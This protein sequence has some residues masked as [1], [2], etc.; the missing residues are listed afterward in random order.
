MFGQVQSRKLDRGVVDPRDVPDVQ[1]PDIEG[2]RD[3]RQSQTVERPPDAPRAGERPHQNAAERA[4]Q[5]E[6]QRTDRRAE[7]EEWGGDNHEEHV[8]DHVDAE[9][10]LGERVDRRDERDKDRAKAGEE[11]GH[12][13]GRE[14]AP[15]LAEA[16][17]VH[18]RRQDGEG[19][20]D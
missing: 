5:P 2:S 13:P 8:L 1:A 16:P 6:E 17:R 7:L 12:A 3:E 18:N 9:Q 19:R 20:E 11:R 4:G 14:P 15:H 10:L